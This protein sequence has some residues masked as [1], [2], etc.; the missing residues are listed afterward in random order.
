MEQK[1]SQYGTTRFMA[2]S[3]THLDVYKRQVS[4]QV[5]LGRLVENQRGLKMKQ[6]GR[7][8]Q[9]GSL[10]QIKTERQRINLIWVAVLLWHVW[11]VSFTYGLI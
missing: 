6:F 9:G 10:Y 5:G 4:R 7:L 2:V 3:Y 11:L 8:A 1:K